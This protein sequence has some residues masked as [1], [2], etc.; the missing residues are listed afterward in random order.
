MAIY[1]LS[2]L[3]GNYDRYLKFLQYSNFN[4]RD[5]L[6]IIGDVL[7]RGDKG[8]PLLQDIM[9]RKNINLLKGNHELMMLPILNDLMFQSQAA[10]QAIIQEELAIASIGQK[11]TLQDFCRLTVKE[12]N[13]ITYYLSELPLYEEIEINGTNFILVHAGLPDFSD[14]P[15]EYY[16]ENELMFGPHDFYIN[17]YDNGSKIIVGHLPTKFIN[18]A[19]PHKIYHIND[20]IAIDC[21]CGFGGQLGVLCLNTM[22]EMYF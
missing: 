19:T 17:H 13:E 3:H 8:I 6:Y 21:G 5:T 4:N 22:E 20:T 7:D 18:G 1:V 15:I 11:E 16:D 14:M 9:K 12:Q 10:Q 2:D